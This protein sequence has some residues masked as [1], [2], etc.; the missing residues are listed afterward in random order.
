MTTAMTFHFKHTH[1][2]QKIDIIKVHTFFYHIYNNPRHQNSSD[3][4]ISYRQVQSP[5]KKNNTHH[6][7]TKSTNSA[8]K[9]S[10]GIDGAA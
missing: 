4:S 6:L 8:E 3:C 2:Q 9:Y 5:E 7:L 1:Q 10:A